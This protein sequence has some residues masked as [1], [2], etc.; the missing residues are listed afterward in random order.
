MLPLH[1]SMARLPL[2]ALCALLLGACASSPVLR[3][4]KDVREA[5]R[6]GEWAYIDALLDATTQPNRD[7]QAA[8]LERLLRYHEALV[9]LDPSSWPLDPAQARAL[10]NPD[11]KKEQAALLAAKRQAVAERKEK[12][13]REFERLFALSTDFNIRNLCL[14][15][16]SRCGDSNVAPFLAKAILDNDPICSD[17]ALRLLR[18]HL[19]GTFALSA[20]FDV[21][22]RADFPVFST[23][24]GNLLLYPPSEAT[25]VAL[26]NYRDLTKDSAKRRLL[27]DALAGYPKG[28]ALPVVTGGSN[29]APS[30]GASNAAPA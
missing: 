11:R 5:Y 12:I 20:T 9:D 30:A 26:A 1:V 2:L 23:A 16:R 4:L 18:P 10:R 19:S 25:R 21:F 3:S 14:W 28:E 27:A 29:A 13:E 15:A 22:A 8:S 24:L 7:V 6:P 17:L